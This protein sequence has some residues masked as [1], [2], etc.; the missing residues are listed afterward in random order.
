MQAGSI[1]LRIVGYIT[2]NNKMNIKKASATTVISE[3]L[4]FITLMV[5]YALIILSNI[6]IGYNMYDEGLTLYG[7]LRVYNGE[8]PYRDFWAFY[9]PGQYYIVASVYKLFSVSVMSVRVFG[10]II[11]FLLPALVYSLS[12]KIS[13]KKYVVFAP[14]LTALSISLWGPAYAYGITLAVFTALCSL[15]FFFNYLSAETGAAKRNTDFQLFVSGALCGLTVF[16]R[17]DIGV[18]L[19][20]SCLITLTALPFYDKNAAKTAFLK[21]T[22]VF[23]GVFTVLI[24]YIAYNVG[25]RVLI[26]NTLIYPLFIWTKTRAT[27]YPKLAMRFG[28]APFYMPWLIYLLTIVCLTREHIH[29][30][31]MGPTKWMAATLLFAGIFF[32]NYLRTRSDIMHSLP[33]NAAAFILTPFL[34]SSIDS[35]DNKWLA[36]AGRAF[37]YLLVACGTLSFYG[38]AIRRMY[39]SAWFLPLTAMTLLFLIYTALSEG[40]S[41]SAGIRWGIKSAFIIFLAAATLKFYDFPLSQISRNVLMGINA[42]YTVPSRFAR[43]KGILVTPGMEDSMGQAVE[44]IQKNTASEEKIFV[45]NNNHDTIG[46]NNILF[47]FLA[48]RGCG[49]R[50]HELPQG[51]A[52]TEAGQKEIATDIVKNRV[53][54]IVIEKHLQSGDQKE[55]GSVYLDNFIRN[56]YKPELINENYM[57]LY[58]SNPVI[59]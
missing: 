26:E 45:G 23:L 57:V 10:S 54:R 56:N 53:R 18:Y 58:S 6:R 39:I 36:Q 21:Y 51:I 12:I 59:L 13:G 31:P 14:L 35:M 40:G 47:Y 28:T 15:Y 17:Q 7:S 42:P 43:S 29:K 50:Y 55:N 52:T 37:I 25:I 3:H 33:F 16:I 38:F 34:L 1:S 11:N 49:T 32:F 46:I 4:P 2:G 20:V 9:L 22:L 19:F 44:Y 30:R 5:F 27:A 48:E 24:A 41:Q 8:L